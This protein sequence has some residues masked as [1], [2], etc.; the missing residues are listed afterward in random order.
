MGSD[1]PA[2]ILPAGTVTF[3]L[4]EVDPASGVWQ[5]APDVAAAALDRHLELVDAV[6]S[7]QGGSRPP[8]QDEADSVLAVFDSAAGAAA[9]A[10]EVHRV[11]DAEPWPAPLALRARVALHTGEALLRDDRAY[12]G[13]ALRRCGRLRDVAHGGQTVMSSVTA[14]ILA[15]A[16]PPGT[17]LQDLGAHRLRDLSLPEQ[18]FELRPA[19]RRAEFPALRS[20]DAVATNLPVQLTS[21][22]GRGDE[23]GA[24]EL[25][26][27]GDRM[28]TLTGAG[29]SGKTR[30]ALQAGAELADRWPDGVW[31]IDLSPVTDPTLVADVAAAACRV[32]VEPVGG[33]L[34]ALVH[35]LR[36]RQALVCL[37]NCE[38]LLESSAE[39]VEVLL[40]SCPGVRVLATSREPL[41]VPGE[42]VWRVPSLAGGEAVS[43]FMDRASRVRPWFTLDGTNEAAVSTLCRRLD[44]MPLA[45]ELAAAWLRTLTP[46]QIAAGLDD[47][48]ALLVRGPRGTVARQ[49]TL[50]ASIDW[51]YDLL[52]DTDRV[53]FR[54]LAVFSGA[55]SLDAARAVCTGRPLGPDAVLPALGRLVD[56]S[57]VNMDDQDGEARYRLLETIRQY[58]ADRLDEAGEAEA[59]G[60]RHLDHYLAFAEAAE[61][62][63]DA[64]D[65]DVWLA[66]L[67]SEHDNLR[68]ALQWGL[69][70]EDPDRAR[71]LAGALAWLWHLH[72][73]G[74]EGVTY[75]RRAIDR[76]PDDRSSLQAKLLTGIAL[77]ADTNGPIALEL[78]AALQGAEIAAAIGDDRQLGRCLLLAAVGRFYTDPVAALDLCEQARD[79]A[80]ASGDDFVAAGIVALQGI[81]LANLNRYDEAAPLLQEGVERCLRRGDR[82]FATTAIGSQ[83]DAAARTG[84]LEGAER[85]AIEGL[86]LAQPLGDF[87]VVGGS[88]GHLAWV[89][90]LRG[91]LAGAKELM[92]GVVRSVEGAEHEVLVPKMT[93]ILGELLLWSGD[94][95]EAVA[96][97]QQDA[98]STDPSPDSLV[99]ARSLPGLA[100]ALRRLGRLKEAQE[101]AERGMAISRMI[102]RPYLLADAL[103]QAGHVAAD[104]GDASQAEDLHHQALAVRVDR[105]MRTLFVDSLDAL[106]GLAATTERFA[107]AA[108][109]LAASDAGRQSLGYPR[110]PVAQPDHA[111]TVAALR[112][113]LGDQ[114]FDAAWAAGTALSLDDAVAYVRRARGSRG[115]PSSGWDSLTPTEQDVVR[116]AA[117]GL[118]NPQ[119]GAR[120]FMSRATVKTHLSHIYAK[121]GVAN[122]IELTSLASARDT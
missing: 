102:D 96:W 90:A 61:A 119:I 21:F 82:T 62:G 41:G 52:D 27:A 101:A 114:A 118:T 25:L 37:D 26:I 70:A 72:G 39:L 88:T 29:G 35:H 16:L 116:L 15:D 84:D 23:L 80:D 73:P 48:F 17:S 9:A 97:F 11:L 44:G 40:R 4:T 95:E 109:L 10:V 89:K 49:Q 8:E 12:T 60:D 122:R 112:A 36:A 64:G 68:T 2:S 1:Q 115:R 93:T 63:L 18:V 103:E 33:P 69:D 53:V 46:A 19:D 6:V 78:E 74:H 108:R 13:E 92:A 98:R 75:L 5:A 51:S 113:A 87:Y 66:R 111:A 32:R 56:K 85:L 67:D 7:A 34:V 71:R 65:R 76:A 57:L 91:D 121:L 100:A 45:I 79:R 54:R 20:L 47:R 38:H 55:F 22:V 104:T 81:I 50:A 30:L 14:A 105:G 59:A 77:T 99:V 3:L 42:T 107:E 83:V 43:L 106:A 94:L 110:A 120:L 28:V 31:W 58:G 24:V 117:E 86:R